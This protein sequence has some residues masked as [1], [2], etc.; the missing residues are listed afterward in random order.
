VFS[1]DYRVK[2]WFATVAQLSEFDAIIDVRSPAEFADDHIPGAINCPVLDN[3]ERARVGTIYQQLSPFEARKIGAALVARNI[4]RYV[5]EQ[6]QQ[7]PKQ[8]RP[9]IYCWRGGQRSGAFTHILREIGWA[10][11]RLEGGYKSWRHH[12]IEALHTIPPQ[13]SFRAIC[14]P[15][16][17]GK[18]RLLE[19]LAIDGAQVLHLEQL[20]AHRGSVL[21]SLPEEEQPSQRMFETRLMLALSAFDS[22]QPVFV[23]S[24]SRRIGVLNLPDPLFHAMR[25]A[26][27]LM[28][29]TRFA[30]RVAFLLRDYAYF[31]TDV[32]LNE[33][34]QRLRGLQSNETLARWLETV[35]RG[36]FEKLVTELLQMHYDP[37]YQ[38]SLR[39][40]FSGLPIPAYNLDDVS[41]AKL[42][43]LA[44]RIV[45]DAS[46]QKLT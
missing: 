33:H 25:A 46:A 28:L 45:A 39:R 12:V 6:F 17:S 30:A 4:A 20:A 10:A 40:H 1:K 44:K 35:E 2:S 18:S 14:G 16:G 27:R 42:R 29:E 31:L 32:N 21:G 23:E 38:S 41:E 36:E 8:W 3:E 5:A 11:Q 43:A 9:L 26:P 15:T 24:E 22:Q 13:L 19:A 37:H 7:H 34:L